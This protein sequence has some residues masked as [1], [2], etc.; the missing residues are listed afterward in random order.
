MS[1]CNF[2]REKSTQFVECILVNEYCCIVQDKLSVSL[3]QQQYFVDFTCGRL[4]QQ[5]RQK[6]VREKDGDSDGDSSVC[7]ELVEEPAKET[8]TSREQTADDDWFVL[9]TISIRLVKY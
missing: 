1:L 7:E 5:R 3:L 4:Y 8:M 2:T 6:S 9:I